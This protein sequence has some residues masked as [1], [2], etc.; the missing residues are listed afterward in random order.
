MKANQSHGMQDI[1]LIDTLIGQ[2]FHDKLSKSHLSSQS[3]IQTD[4]DTPR[5]NTDISPL[6]SNDQG[7]YQLSRSL[8]CEEQHSGPEISRLFERALDENEM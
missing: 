1:D 5:S 6:I 7:H 2:S 8:L 3:D 4:F